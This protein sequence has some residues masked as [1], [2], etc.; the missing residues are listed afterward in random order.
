MNGLDKDQFGLLYTYSLY[1]NE[2]KN[3]YLQYTAACALA[4]YLSQ[5]KKFNYNLEELLVYDYLK[6][7]LYIWESKKFMADINTLRGL[8]LLNRARCRSKTSKDIN[9]HQ[10]T[11]RGLK[12]LED[13][14]LS[15]PELKEYFTEIDALLKDVNGNIKQIILGEDQPYLQGRNNKAIIEG[16]VKKFQESPLDDLQYS[17]S[18]FF[19]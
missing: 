7:R 14:V 1:S 11:R 12:Y 3:Q 15:Q 2:A 5:N 6:Q 8:N 18:S 4:Y 17:S 9:A 10:C 13:S 19:V 16:F